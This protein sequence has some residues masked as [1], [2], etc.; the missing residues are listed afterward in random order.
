MA[1]RSKPLRWRRWR[2][3]AAKRKEWTLKEINRITGDLFNY[4]RYK[5]WLDR[6]MEDRPLFRRMKEKYGSN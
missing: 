3:R 1:T 4:P 5:A 6:A 2:S